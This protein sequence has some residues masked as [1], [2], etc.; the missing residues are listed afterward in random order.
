MFDSPE[1]LL[2]K[3]QLGE[4]SLL[5]LKEVTF[6]GTRIAGPGRGEL[7][8]ELTAMA[9]TRQGGVLVLGVHDRSRDIVGIPLDRLDDVESYVR[10]IC[11]DTVEPP[12]VPQI[13]RLEL[14]D[15]AGTLQPIL[16]ID[17]PR[18]LFVHRSAGRY[19]HRIG[20]SK[21]EMSTE[22]LARLFQQRS[23]ARVI[24]F[25]EQAVPNTVPADLEVD[26]YDRF[27][28]R[29]T[30]DPMVKLRKLGLLVEDESGR[31]QASVAGVLL[32]TGRAERWLPSALI[33]A[34]RYRGVR[35]D[36]NYQID[37]KP[38]TGPLD[39]QVRQALEFARRNMT[40]RAVKQPARVETPQFSERAV[41][42]ALV[43]AVAHRDYSIHGS[44]IRLFL[45]DDRLELYSPGS[46]PNSVTVESLALRQ[47]TRNELVTSLLARCRVGE[48]GDTVKREYLMERRGDGVPIILDESTDLSGR[49]PVYRLIDD[50]ELL[51]TIWSAQA[52]LA[53]RGGR[54]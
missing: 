21:R 39:E 43:N 3:I 31:L 40:V 44:K 11:N 36:S 1:E 38:I 19:F 2:R 13:V 34:V 53:R 35:Q 16:R 26:L 9:N 20:S 47:A 14:P 32:A 17:V 24:R 4:D 48:A 5:E 25:D 33:E 42:E 22:L 27:V 45:F 50:T 28:G 49:E 30:G 12:L 8:D 41:F 7:S 29:T 46:L 54:P 10:E 18:S 23:Q 37:A 6:R 51:L 52:E 15:A